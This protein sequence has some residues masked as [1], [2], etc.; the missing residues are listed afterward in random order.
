M[1]RIRKI[2]FKDKEILIVD[3]SDCKGEEMIKVFNEGKKLVLSENKR[4]L[5]LKIFNEKTFLSPD[6]MRFLEKEISE[7][8]QFIEK[9][10]VIGISTIQGWIIKGM[11]LWMKRQIHIYDSM[12]EAL[13]F[14]VKEK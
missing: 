9:H 2:Y 8:D 4:Y 14:L 1:E 11:N 7:I 10:A 13:E 5:V 6:F 3:Y 12:D